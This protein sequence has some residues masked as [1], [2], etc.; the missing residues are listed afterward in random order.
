MWTDNREKEKSEKIFHNEYNLSFHKPR[1]D[2]CLQC[3]KHK[4]G[5]IT[6][7]AYQAHINQKMMSREHKQKQVA[8]NDQTFYSATFDMQQVLS[9]PQCN[10]KH[11]ILENKTLVIHT[12]LQKSVKNS[13]KGH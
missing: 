7:A 6:E 13:P 3:K 4:L 9:T 12:R 2:S 5:L 8:R 1:K 10:N 11:N